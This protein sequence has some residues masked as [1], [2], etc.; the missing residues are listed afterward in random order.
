M[1]TYEPER[2]NQKSQENISK[3]DYIKTQKVEIHLEFKI[4]ARWAIG[5]RRSLVGSVLVY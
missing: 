3:E 4:S 1:Y 2:R 5:S